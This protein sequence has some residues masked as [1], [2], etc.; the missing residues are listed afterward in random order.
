MNGYY[1]PGVTDAD[2]DALSAS[3]NDLE[4][5]DALKR[6]QLSLS[7]IAKDF[8]A[9]EGFDPAPVSKFLDLIDNEMLPYVAMNLGEYGKPVRRFG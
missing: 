8:E 4:R 9:I 2:I 7:G 5:E 6:I 3:D 1:A